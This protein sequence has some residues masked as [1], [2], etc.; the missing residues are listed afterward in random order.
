V[1]VTAVDLFSGPGGFTIGMKRAGVE[2]AA[3]VEYDRDAMG[4]YDQHTSEA[5]HYCDDIQMVDLTP[6]RGTIDLV[7][8]GPPC[9][10]FSTG[11]LRRGSRD[12]RDML[13]AF[14][15][16][17]LLLRPEAV[18]MENVPGLATG[19][20]R[21]YLGKALE[22]LD[23][24][25]YVPRFAILNAADYGVPQN[26]RRLFLVAL[27]DREFRFPDPTHGPGTAKP[28]VPVLEALRSARADEPNNSVVTYAKR[29]DIRPSP[30]DGHLFNG[31]GRPLD[32]SKPSRTILASAGGNKT[33]FVDEHDLVPDYH[34][35]LLSGGERRTG[36]LPGG[37]R[38]TVAES[39]AIQTFP[40]ELE[41][42][43][44]RSSQ[45]RQVGDAV[46]PL[47][48]EIVGG[49]VVSQLT[50]PETGDRSGI[51]ERQLSL[52]QG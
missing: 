4:T 41:F 47:L 27:R 19:S 28:A 37:R 36:V 2:I 9:Q 6:L 7:Y 30:Y 26:R 48:A 31:G 14:L 43:G 29:P 39:A 24:A 44:S 35:H 42:C 5:T 50:D 21:R 18:I 22:T 1:T 49:A 13:P 51:G 25:G 16:N 3:A 12:D 11:G 23:E 20:R 34:A 38:L 10:P 15:K 32:L 33:H 8:G 17:V 45:Y 40:A 46:P 52:L